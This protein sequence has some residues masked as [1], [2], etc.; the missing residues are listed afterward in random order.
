MVLVTEG[1]GYVEMVCPHLSRQSSHRSS[2]EEEEQEDERRSGQYKRVRAQLSTGDMFVV[3]A[4]HPVTY[5]ASQNQN[6]GLVGFGLYSGQDNKR[7]FVAG[8]INNVRQWDSQ[9]KELAFGVESKLVDEVFNN[10]PQESYFVS[11]QSQRGS[12]ERRG[13]T[14]P[15]SSFLDF[16][17][18]F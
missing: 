13:S 14:N 4:D 5:V 12:D 10:K 7:I 2:R 6:L 3:P 15:L 1:N 17:R 9:A 8:K 11:R 16:A 18:L